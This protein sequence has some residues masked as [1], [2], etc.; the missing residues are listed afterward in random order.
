MRRHRP[1]EMGMQEADPTFVWRRSIGG[2]ELPGADGAVVAALT[3][4]QDHQWHMLLHAGG[5][6]YVGVRPDLETAVKALSDL[7]HKE[8]PGVWLRASWSAVLEPWQGDLT[9]R[10][11]EK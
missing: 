6:R 3:E 4:A 7:M 10:L 9:E 2:Y 5:K 1:S 11:E 8:T